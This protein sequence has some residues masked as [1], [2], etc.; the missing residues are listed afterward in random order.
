LL[1]GGLILALAAGCSESRKWKW[2]PPS[3]DENFKVALESSSGDDRREAVT[4]IAESNYL[5]RED[6]FHVF[7]AVARTDPVAQVRCIAARALGRYYDAR[8]V[9]TLVAILTATA[10]SKDALPAN[11]DVRW[12]A[13]NSLI[14]LGNR[15][16]L[17]GPQRETVLELHIKLLASDPSR[18]VRILAAQALGSFRDRRVFAPLIAGLRSEDFAQ[19]DRCEQ[20]LIAL[21]GVTHDYD[22]D[23]WQAWVAAAGDPFAKAGQKPVTTRPAGPNWFDRQMRAWRRGLKLRNAD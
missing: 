7:D 12:E 21:T 2:N 3:A 15:G 6:A 18:N 10:E 23:V 17:E 20:S 11:D 9:P 4:R 5:A 8:P 19:A 14:A 22:P 16:V 1:R 13:V